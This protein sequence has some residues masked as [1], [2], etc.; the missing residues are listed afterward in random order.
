MPARDRNQR[1][2]RFIRD[3]IL[4][5]IAVGLAITAGVLRSDRGRSE[6]GQS[7]GVAAFVR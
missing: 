2:R 4:V 6:R 5:L 3:W 7:T 1:R